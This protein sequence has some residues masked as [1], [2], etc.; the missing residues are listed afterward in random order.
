MPSTQ[1]SVETT[2]TPTEVMAFMTDFGPTRADHWPN[3][4]PS[5]YELHE[6]G[7]HWAEVTEGNT[8]GWERVRYS[9]DSETA[10]ITIDTLKSN[11]WGPGSGWKYQL[12]S[13]GTGT[14]LHLTLTRHGKSVL[15]RLIGALIP[16]AG[17]PALRRQFESTLRRAENG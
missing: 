1:F 3:V 2:L 9:W 14:T 17:A 5:H 7:D 12:A 10:T 13:T 8:L 11:L 16:I 4:D 6:Q 15:G